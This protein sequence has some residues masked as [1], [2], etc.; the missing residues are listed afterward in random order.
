M[1]A[2]RKHLDSLFP[3]AIRSALHK[4][5]LFN[6]F[7][8]NIKT[9]QYIFGVHAG[10]L[11]VQCHLCIDPFQCKYS[12]F[13]QQCSDAHVSQLETERHVTI[14][15]V[16]KLNLTNYVSLGIGHF[17]SSCSHFPVAI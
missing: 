17:T 10:V 6:H 8:S 3:N 1:E 12:V 11:F 7:K 2:L 16:P 4:Y 13:L 5:L 14:L 15:F 9:N